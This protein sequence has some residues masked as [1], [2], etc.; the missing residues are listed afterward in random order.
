MKEAPR[1]VV[2][3]TGAARGIGWAI[4]KRFAEKG[5]LL[6][7]NY[8]H[9]DQ[10][11]D[12]DL[13]SELAKANGGDMVAI[14]GDVSIKEEAEQFIVEAQRHFGKIDVLVNNAGITKIGPTHLFA[15]QD[16][17]RIIATNLTATFTCIR[18]VLPGMIERSSGCIIN[19]SSEQGLIGYPTYAAYCA[20][21]G[22]VIAMTKAIAKEVAPYGILVNSVA[23][24]PIETD[25]LMK[26]STEYNDETR[27]QVPLLRFG[28][29]DEIANVVEFLAGPGGSYFVGQIISPNGGTAI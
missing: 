29:P 23:P 3:I 7:L 4:A 16:W 27:M 21:K 5:Q 15:W 28:K 6:A 11:K 14:Q 1:K 17:D 2:A 22:G 9:S 13:L 25:M 10:L 26:D 12:L 18:A 19:I 24:G 20:S 8:L